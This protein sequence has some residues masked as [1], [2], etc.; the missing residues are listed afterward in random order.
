MPIRVRLPMP[1]FYFSK[2]FSGPEFLTDVLETLQA[3]GHAN[4]LSLAKYL[5]ESTMPKK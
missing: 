5:V 2:R 4:C 3:A 1:L